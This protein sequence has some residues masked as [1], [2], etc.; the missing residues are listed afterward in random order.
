MTALL[1]DPLVQAVAGILILVV[2]LM[3]IYCAMVQRDK[4]RGR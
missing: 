4:E 1:Q 2:G 3:V